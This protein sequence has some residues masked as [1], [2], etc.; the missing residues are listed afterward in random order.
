MNP[1]K[2]GSQSHI[3]NVRLQIQLGLVESHARRSFLP[4]EK[5]EEIFS[6]TTIQRVIENLDC[7][8]DELI[9]LPRTIR[10]G[11]R[12]VLAMLIWCNRLDLIVTFRNYGFLDHRLPLEEDDAKR[13]AGDFDGI[14][15]A[16]R[17]QWIFCPYV[18]PEKMWEFHRQIDRR[19]ILPFT[20]TELIGD[21]AF[22]MIDKI[23]ISPS[24]QHFM[25]KVVSS[26]R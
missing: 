25:H 7:D 6:P 1:N 24:Q 11:G 5:L 13:L 14:E 23:S 21:G 26:H 17:T 3:E 2:R 18:F 9:S 16:R 22:G 4:N 20:K 19:V 12:K 15:L 10:D 8:K